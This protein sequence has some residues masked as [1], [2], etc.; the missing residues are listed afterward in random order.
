[1]GRQE[2]R[3]GP[4]SARSRFDTLQAQ[5]LL[6][7]RNTGAYVLDPRLF[8]LTL[9]GTFG[10]SQERV[11]ASPGGGDDSRDGT[12]WGYEASAGLLS[13]HPV[14][15]TL[16]ANRRQTIQ[17]QV[18]S[19]QSQLLSENRGATLFLKRLYIPSTVSV[20]QELV[21]DEFRVAES[22]VHRQEERRSLT[23]E[24]QRGWE[25]AELDVRYEF[26]DFIDRV[27]TGLSYQSH[28]PS[29]GFS[30]EFGPELNWR[31]D[32]RLR[33]FT[34]RGAETAGI[35]PPDLTTWSVDE[36]LEIEHTERLR[37]RYQYLLLETE[38]PGGEITT[39]TVGA[40]LHHQLYE[41]LRTTAAADASYQTVPE[42]DRRIGRGR[43]DL[44]YTKRL[45][46]EGRLSI[47]LGGGMQYEDDRLR[48][49]ESFVAQEPHTASSP[50]ALP[51]SLA[52]R[53]VVEA[54]VVV[55]RTAAGPLPP[56]CVPPGP[57]PLLLVLG[58][59]YTL[60]TV[61][62][63]TE[64][65]PIPCGG[66]IPGINPGDTI[67]VDYRFTTPPARTFMTT[68]GRADVSLDYG[69]VRLFAGYDRSDQSLLSGQD[70]EFLDD[71]ETRSAGLEL[72]YER[73]RISASAVGEWRRFLSTTV[74]YD[75]Y[76]TTQLVRVAIL[77]ELT[78]SVSGYQIRLDYLDQDRHSLSLGGRLT[79]TYA[80]NGD[81]FGE[82]TV[83]M[84]QLKDTVL[85][86]ERLIDAGL[87]VRWMLRKLEISPSVQFF[88][89]ERG[90]TRSRDF[91]ATLQ[92][93]RRF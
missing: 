19:G 69:W 72:R 15:L 37:S 83:G 58:R 61:G 48:A 55:T 86:R 24:G 73:P 38:T 67:A 47:G 49:R 4:D 59:D 46:G 74:S 20:R 34:R 13:G 76:R 53:F 27:F 60:R 33:Y 68:S 10:L 22:V 21:D 9:G 31:W 18:L 77:P 62:T 85:P 89:R 52:N 91:R 70:G 1:V 45:P 64:V 32:S 36:S 90:D 65:V 82:M 41:S 12:L 23:Y 92:M 57:P 29:L 75:S 43:L 44:A 26:V 16:Y 5:E 30:L 39:H 71:Q 80:L 8:T 87:R 50:F 78:L 63:V 56:G 35:S 28:E 81:L 14:S 11:S 6:T 3:S 66:A 84:Q 40:S 88:D 25:S 51:I 7:I 93:I 2:T 17:P 54:S 79:A 42:G